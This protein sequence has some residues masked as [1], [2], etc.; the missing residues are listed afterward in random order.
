MDVTRKWHLTSE[1][2]C[3]CYFP[4]LWLRHELRT[5][6]R[7]TP[8]WYCK[9]SR[10]GSERGETSLGI[11]YT[12]PL[13]RDWEECRAPCLQRKV[14]K[15]L[16]REGR[17]VKRNWNK[18]DSGGQCMYKGGRLT[19]SDCVRNRWSC[20]T[21]SRSYFPSYNLILLTDISLPS[22][23][24]SCPLPFILTIPLPHTLQLSL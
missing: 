5:L 1:C 10:R 2:A 12:H 18:S 22:Y 11:R 6:D 4:V 15:R 16:E 19:L 20:R 8:S 24:F 17:V 23:N 21:A 7:A 14:N 13:Q 9:P 3:L